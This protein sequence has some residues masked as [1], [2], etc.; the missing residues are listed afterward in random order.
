MMVRE[1]PARYR[2]TESVGR[3]MRTTACAETFSRAR[4]W[5]PRRCPVRDVACDGGW[6]LELPFHY[7]RRKDME[8]KMR[9]MI[10]LKPN[11][12]LNAY[13]F[14]TFDLACVFSV[15]TVMPYLGTKAATYGHL[16]PKKQAIN[17]LCIT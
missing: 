7:V 15:E 9:Q 10:S 11:M 6:S 14:N 16:E 5:S 4:G 17:R 13:D 12:N 3:F 2:V 8:T 1:V